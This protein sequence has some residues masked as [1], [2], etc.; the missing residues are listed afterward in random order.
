MKLK[1]SN[2]AVADKNPGYWQ[3]GLSLNVYFDSRSARARYK[4]KLRLTLGEA[5]L[6]GPFAQELGLRLRLYKWSWNLTLTWSSM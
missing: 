4:N 1:F 6:V 3:V 5:P 2:I